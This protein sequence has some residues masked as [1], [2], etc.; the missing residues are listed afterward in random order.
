[1]NLSLLDFLFPKRC[2]GCGR[3]GTYFCSMCILSSKLHFWQVCPVCERASLDGVTHIRCVQKDLPDGLTAIWEYSGAPRKLISKLKY[4]FVKESAVTLA[5][6]A[7]GFLKNMARNRPETPKWSD[8]KLAIVP[9]PLHWTRK[10]WRGF[11]HTEEIAKILAGM[12][13]WKVAPVLKRTKSTKPQ[14]GL[15]EKER[16]KNV[17]GIFTIN[18]HARGTFATRDTRGTLVLF[19]DVWTTGATMKEAAKVLKKAGIK[20]VWCLTLA[21]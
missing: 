9:V 18:K 6:S 16:I 21:R 11:N 3:A 13:G 14:V 8:S 20:K 17:Q 5:S 4:K 15:K 10:N 2:A 12:M 19:D 1:M 7:A